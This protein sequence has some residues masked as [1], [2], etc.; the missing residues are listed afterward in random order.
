MRKNFLVSTGLI[1]TWEFEENNF[2]LGRWCE[3]Y[4]Y[5]DFDEKGFDK[6]I[7]KK[8]NIIKNIDHWDDPEKKN[9]DYKYLERKIE[10]VL[11]NS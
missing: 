1:D 3:F 6:K 9:K 8:N 10:S 7:L 2:L 4:E 5:D 11:Y